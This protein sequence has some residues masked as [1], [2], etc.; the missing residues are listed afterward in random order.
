MN[1][2]LRFL[3]HNSFLL[4]VIAF[5]FAILA[6]TCRADSSGKLEKHAR[7]IEK[8]LARYRT[9]TL[10]QVDFR[11]DSEALGSL[12][13]LSNTTFKITN[14]DSNKVQ[15]FNYADVSSVKMT[16]EYIGAGSGFES[17]HHIRLWK[18]LLVGAVL[19]GGGIAAYETMH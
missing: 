14:S 1:R 6:P 3:H 19:A 5:A 7:K 15:T 11:D 2:I 12:G 4:V 18:P 16:K 8:R 13:D 9:G 10:V 17:W